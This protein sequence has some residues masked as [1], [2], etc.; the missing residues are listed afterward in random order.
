MSR[1]PA[2]DFGSVDELR[3]AV[4]THL[5]YSEWVAVD[6]ERIDTFA[7]ATGDRQWIHVDP[8]R[9]AAGP[10]GSTIGHGYLT[11]SLLPALVGSF[12][13]YS[14]W[15]VKVN[16][17]SNRV[18]FL[19]PVR[20]DSRVRAGVTVTSVTETPAGTQLV[21][22]VQVDIEDAA[23]EPGPRP[24]LVAEVITLLTAPHAQTPP[25]PTSNPGW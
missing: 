5:G 17:G 10:F 2:R 15:P 25:A 12:V 19:T 16:Y 24:A 14:G 22:Q 1:V 3:A 4:G 9:A 13:E 21:T 6:Q 20:V 8:R 23:G 11:L 18:R 7:A